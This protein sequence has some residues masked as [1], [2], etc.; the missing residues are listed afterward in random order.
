M[1]CT[2]HLCSSMLVVRGFLT[3]FATLFSVL[4]AQAIP[5]PLGPGGFVFPPQSGLAPSGSPIITVTSP[6]VSATLNGTLTSSVYSNS[7]LSALVFTYQI[8]LSP[9]SPSAVSQLSISRFGSFATTVSFSGNSPTYVP[10]SFISRSNEGG[11]V[12]DVMQFH[13]GPPGMTESLLPGMTSSLL[14]VETDSRG[15]QP[16]TASIIDGVAVPNIP[17]FAPLSVPEPTVAV[18]GL[19]GLIGFA[20]ARRKR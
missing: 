5:T 10:P 12:G 3:L 13:F 19:A 4:L 11:G 9:N 15:F 17:S 18:F 14:I 1:R 20:F 7:T 6:F 2:I 8:N 16:T